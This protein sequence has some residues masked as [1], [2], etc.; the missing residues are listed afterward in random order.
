MS[1]LAATNSDVHVLEQL[2]AV[3]RRRWKTLFVFVAAGIALGAL[4]A[5][6][7]PPQYAS[8]ATVIVRSGFAADPLRQGSA[9]TT[10]EEEGQFLSQLELIK[11]SSVANIVAGKLA[12]EED[13][14]FDKSELAGWQRLIARVEVL[15]GRKT[16]LATAATSEALTRDQVVARLQ[17][18]VKALRAGRTYVAAISFTHS[19]PATAQKIAQTYAE[20]LRQ[21]LAEVSDLATSRVRAALEAEIGRAA[22][23]DQPALQQKYHNLVVDRALPGMDAAIISDAR[24]PGAPIAPR[25]GFLVTVGAVLG[26]ALGCLFAGY[27]EMSDRGV[28]DGDLLARRLGT[29]FLGYVPILPGTRKTFGTSDAGRFSLPADAR[30]SVTSPFVRFSETVRSAAVAALADA[31]DGR[32]K[33]IGVI[34]VLPGEGKTLF[35][36]NLAAQI[37]NRGKRVLLID[38]HFRDPDL[39]GWLVGRPPVGLFDTLLQAKPASETMLYDKSS[40]V[41][42]LPVAANNRTADPAEV[43]AGKQLAALLASERAVQDI[44]IIDLP[45]LASASDAMAIEPLVDRFLLVTE[46]GGPSIDLVANMIEGES[47]IAAKLAGVAI[48]KTDLRKLSIYVSGNS[49]GAFQYRIG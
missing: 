38:G 21:K 23:A 43:L 41:S 33:V 16:G 39:T 35:C 42:L 6:S 28:R 29:R 1:N 7:Q 27:R 13:A 26:A 12:L 32:A 46:W 5:E 18:N 22:P 37:G 47:A 17:A 30:L 20:A 8:S 49:R 25:K 15:V 48:T 3:F 34:S 11:S 19:D 40:N 45:A 44:I 31:E 4:Y 10:P 2:L 36:G 24:M 14:A 9:T